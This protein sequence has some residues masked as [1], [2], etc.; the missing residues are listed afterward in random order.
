MQW[1]ECSPTEPSPS[2]PTRLHSAPLGLIHDYIRPGLLI[3]LP[4]SFRL[5]SALLGF[6]CLLILLFG[7]FLLYSALL[8]FLCLFIVLLGFP[9]LLSALL[10]PTLIASSPANQRWPLRHRQPGRKNISRVSSLPGHSRHGQENRSLAIIV[11]I[12]CF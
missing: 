4:C 10:G 7:S 5:Y 2:S 11:L 3:L 1:P 12:S 8:G 9:R 6:L